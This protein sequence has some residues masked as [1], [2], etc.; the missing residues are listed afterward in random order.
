MSKRNSVAGGTP[1]ESQNKGVGEQENK[2]LNNIPVEHQIVKKNNKLRVDTR[3]SKQII[4]HGPLAQM[5]M[6]QPAFK[7]TQKTLVESALFRHALETLEIP[8][9]HLFLHFL[10]TPEQYTHKNSQK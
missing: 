2:L 1:T 7:V 3:C 5:N 4:T 10:Q 8:L 6:R 9:S